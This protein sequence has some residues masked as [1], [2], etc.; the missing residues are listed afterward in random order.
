MN[1]SPGSRFGSAVVTLPSATQI[2]ITRVF[3]A[4]AEIVFKA[5]TTPELVRRWWGSPENPLTV[6]D[7]D[8]R[9]G[10]NWRY[11]MV[12][13]DAELGW[14][15]TYQA[16]DAPLRLVST[17]VFEGFPNG[18]AVNTLTLDEAD[19]TTT[20]TVVVQHQTMANRD[21]HIDS[22]MEAG[23]QTTLDRLDILTVHKHAAAGCAIEGE[24]PC[25]T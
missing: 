23:M 16:I 8:L 18:E 14:H 4:P 9:V 10:G 5:W 17:E 25:P 24:P 13:G 11:A 1:Q 2:Q 22:G 3:D 20:L 6:C 12:M 19:G 15:G 7:I 21:G